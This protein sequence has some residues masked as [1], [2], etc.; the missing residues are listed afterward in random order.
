MRQPPTG[1]WVETPFRPCSL[2]LSRLSISRCISMQVHP[3]PCH[4][5]S[6]E[7]GIRLPSNSSSSLRYLYAHRLQERTQSSP[8]PCSDND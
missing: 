1:F 6:R 4:K 5:T 8:I 7:G 2:P 3:D